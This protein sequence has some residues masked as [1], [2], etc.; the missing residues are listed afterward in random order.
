[1][2]ECR[3]YAVLG[4]FWTDKHIMPLPPRARAVGLALG[5]DLNTGYVFGGRESSVSKHY[6]YCLEYSQAADT[7]AT[8]NNMPINKASHSGWTLDDDN[9]ILATGTKYTSSQGFSPETY[10]YTKSTDS[11]LQR[12]NIIAP[13]RDSAGCFSMNGKGYLCGGS[14][15]VSIDIRYSPGNQYD[16]DEFDDTAEV[17]TSLIGL[18]V[19]AR[20]LSGGGALTSSGC[21]YIIGGRGAARK[22]DEYDRAVDVWSRKAD[23]PAD[24]QDGIASEATS[25]SAIYIFGGWY[26][27]QNY[28][29]TMPAVPWVASLTPGHEQLDVPMD[30]NISFDILDETGVDPNTITVRINGVNAI[31]NGVFQANFTGAIE[32][33]L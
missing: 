27:K 8:R 32:E 19:P 14:P 5:A 2:Q 12:T 1:M 15:I 21:G 31:V 26:G 28:V 33:I 22:C 17:W 23:I 9:G 16:N 3:E 30:T 20:S 11:Y 4:D 18:I 7:W 24:M 25:G 13:T 29:F 6:N 10:R